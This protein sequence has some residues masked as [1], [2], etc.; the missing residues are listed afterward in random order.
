MNY[1]LTRVGAALLAGVL[2][3]ALL[4][5][6][7]S[8]GPAGSA[9]AD[10]AAA[11]SISGAAASEEQANTYDF[12]VM[13]LTATLPA[14]L[15]ERL[16]RGDLSLYCYEIPTEDGSALQYA[17][18]WFGT[19]T[20]TQPNSD[21]AMYDSE[22][23][24]YLDCIGVLGVYQAGMEDQ[25]EALTGCDEHT[26]LGKSA[27]SA[28]EYFL[29][30]NTKADQDLIAELKQI[31]TV[32]T[33]MAPYQTPDQ[34]DAPQS[35][36]TGTS[37]GEFTTQDINGNSVTQ[38]IFKDYDLTMV[39][40][41]TT[42]CSPCVGEIPDLEKLHQEM[43]DRGVNVVGV[44]LDVLNEKGEIDPDT[45]EKAQLLAE[46]TGATYPFLLPDSGCFNGRLTG[47]EAVPETFFVDKDGNIVG[48]TY[49]GSGSYEDWLEVV[50][51]T[52]ATLQ[53]GA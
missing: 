46:Q 12:P 39:N 5:G 33:E 16:E 51:E 27:D 14:P 44:L 8:K 37:L 38:D 9:P 31:Q 45:L 43:A 18:L 47:I 29:S 3:L 50:E 40:V 41:F 1:D 24:Q 10:S 2:C 53:E 42:W 6:C 36:F 28:Y 7:S 26:S 23:E 22:L 19:M 32:F 52:L 25:L 20:E 11:S 34:G 13:G 21:T 17:Q 4:A 48:E 15:M 49:S 30:A 35:E